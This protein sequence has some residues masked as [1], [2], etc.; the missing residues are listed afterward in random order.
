MNI[1]SRGKLLAIVFL[2]IS[3][4]YDFTRE[5]T[6]ARSGACKTVSCQN[7]RWRIFQP[8]NET[9]LNPSS[10]LKDF[11]ESFL[12]YR[13][14][15]LLVLFPLDANRRRD[16]IKGDKIRLIKKRWSLCSWEV[17]IIRSHWIFVPSLYLMFVIVKKV[18]FDFWVNIILQRKFS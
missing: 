1:Y 8:S 9:S 18:H 10:S 5:F 16:Q 13:I 3:M 15:I 2:I 17:K 7:L 6:E 14:F 12:F 11:P 4:L